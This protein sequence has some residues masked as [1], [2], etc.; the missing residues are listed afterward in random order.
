MPSELKQIELE[1]AEAKQEIALADALTRLNKNRDFKLLIRE[2]FLVQQAAKAAQMLA[3][4]DMAHPAAQKGLYDRLIAVGQVSLY[5]D[6]IEHTGNM[7]VKTLRESEN[8]RDE[9]MAEE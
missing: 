4:R 6:S 5:L 2:G 1:V 9:I 8:T 7:A 3:D